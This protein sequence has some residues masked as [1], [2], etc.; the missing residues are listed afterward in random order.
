MRNIKLTIEYEGTAYLG[1]QRQPQGMTIQQALEESLERITGQAPQVIGASRTD[2]G[3]HA[4]GQVANFK[5]DSAMPVERIQSALN[6]LL[7]MDIAILAAEEVP[8]GFNARF[9]A[10][11]KLYHYTIW[12]QRVRPVLD[13]RFCWHV[14]W[15]VALEPLRAASQFL[16]GE[17]D[18]AAFQSAN[19]QSETTVRAVERADWELN[20]PRLT[21]AIEANGFLYNMVR[22]LVGTLLEVGR[23]KITPAEFHRVLESG[24]RTQAGRTAPASGLCLMRVRYD[25]PAPISSP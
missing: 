23:G 22:A 24:E 4:R 18:F 7:P 17:H 15:P 19:A 9:S 2:T 5:T 8:E 14:R 20:L 13:R 11:S 6:A 1:W 12:N 16:I 21:F 10:R 3:V 25:A